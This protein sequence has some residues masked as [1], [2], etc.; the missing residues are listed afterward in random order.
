MSH[1][2]SPPAR[3]I[4]ELDSSAVAGARGR[5]A[6]EFSLCRCMFGGSA[7][8]AQLAYC[9]LLWVDVPCRPCWLPFTQR[10]TEPSKTDSAIN[11]PDFSGFIWSIVAANGAYQLLSLGRQL[12]GGRRHLS[13]S[14]SLLVGGQFYDAL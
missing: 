14:R 12:A 4:L 2:R 11:K 7:P 6:L 9:V 5:P 3:V 8:S 10:L 13:L 1:A